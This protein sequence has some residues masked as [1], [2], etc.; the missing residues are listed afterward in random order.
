MTSITDR[1]FTI[2]N[3][4]CTPGLSGIPRR[5]GD[6]EGGVGRRVARATLSFGFLVSPA[7]SRAFIGPLLR[8]LALVI[9]TAARAKRVAS[10]RNTAGRF[11]A[12]L[13][14]TSGSCAVQ[15]L[16]F[17]DFLLAPQ[18]KVTRLPGR[19]PGTLL[20]INQK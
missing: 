7:W 12:P 20:A 2:V 17:G 11:R 18:K 6:G 10:C 4:G 8:C 16:F 3:A 13:L 19:T 1:R 5:W 15:R 9:G 14:A